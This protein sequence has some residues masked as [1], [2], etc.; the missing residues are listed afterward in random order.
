[1]AKGKDPDAWKR[2]PH[3]DKIRSENMP[4]DGKTN[5]NSRTPVRPS[6]K[7]MPESERHVWKG[8]TH[9]GGPRKTR[10]SNEYD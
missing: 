5:K 10:Y 6:Q 9:K 1:M 7:D 4:N 3:V 2:S 8:G